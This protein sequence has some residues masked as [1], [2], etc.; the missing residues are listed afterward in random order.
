MKGVQLQCLIRC[1]CKTGR[2]SDFGSYF[3]SI[4]ISLQ[5]SEAHLNLVLHFGLL[6]SITFIQCIV[7]WG[8][9]FE[10]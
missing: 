8:V 5:T 4:V 7:T 1:I 2:L 3:R 9:F 6:T 10:R